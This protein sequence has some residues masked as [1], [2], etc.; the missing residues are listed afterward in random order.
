[1]RTSNKQLNPSLKT[2]IEKTFTQTVAD[3]RDL[4][5]TDKFL[6]D[7]LTETEFESFAKRLAVAYW[8]NKG[9][10]YTNIRDNIKVSTATIASVQSMMERPGF[11]LALKKMEAEEW[12]SQWAQKIGSAWPLKK[13]KK[14]G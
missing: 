9:R 10:S 7:F 6:S 4:S 14:T 5:E 13:A 8:L 2:Q 1:M 3:L 11:K 12:A